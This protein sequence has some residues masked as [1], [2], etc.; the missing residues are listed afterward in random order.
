MLTTSIRENQRFCYGCYI[1]L[2]G[3]GF[4]CVAARLIHIRSGVLTILAWHFRRFL[5]RPF[6]SR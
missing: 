6:P 1:L 3:G 4:V 2:Q 5:T